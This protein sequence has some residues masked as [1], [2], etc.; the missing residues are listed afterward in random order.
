MLVRVE[1]DEAKNVKLRVGR[2]VCF[3]DVLEAISQGGLVAVERHHNVA[4]YPNQGLLIVRIS[5]YAYVVPFV[6]SESVLFLKTVFPSR[7]YTK[8]YLS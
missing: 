1:Y 7:K 5:R 3:D 4:K 2:G 6:E 8:V